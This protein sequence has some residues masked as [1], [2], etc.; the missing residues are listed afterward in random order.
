M[1]SELINTY[2]GFHYLDRLSIEDR[3]I[4]IGRL[5]PGKGSLNAYET[6][7]QLYFSKLLLEVEDET[8]DIIQS[9]VLADGGINRL[10]VLRNGD[11][12]SAE[13]TDEKLFLDIRKTALTVPLSKINKTEIGFISPFKGKELVFKTKDMTQKRN[14]KGAKCTDS[15]KVAIANKIGGIMGEP[16]LYQSTD[17]ERP[18]LCVILEILMRWKTE[19]TETT[20]FFG[21]EQTNEM[22][23]ANLRF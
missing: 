17:I 13:Y 12:S 4:L 21:P 10:F 19:A 22:D 23:L 9:I 1:K 18:E 5:F 2:V 11:W 6:I 7:V 8:G 3:L 14:N 20:Y 16:D 15:S